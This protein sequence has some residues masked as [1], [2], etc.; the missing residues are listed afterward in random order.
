MGGFVYMGRGMRWLVGWGVR[1]GRILVGS[2]IIVFPK[3][4]R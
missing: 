2:F 3:S 4:N 1:R